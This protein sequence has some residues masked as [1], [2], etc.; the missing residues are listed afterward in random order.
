M[1]ILMTLLCTLLLS[2]S[3]ANDKNLEVE[4]MIAK[5]KL[6]RTDKS[7]PLKQDGQ[8]IIKAFKLLKKQRDP[9]LAKAYIEA[10]NKMIE[11]FEHY[12]YVE[13]FVILYDKNKKFFDDIINASLNKKDAKR[14][15]EL[16]ALARR[17]FIE[18]NG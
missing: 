13:D 10:T 6:V 12:A 4:K 16:M 18:G 1:K 5:L 17:V 15:Y 3:Y 7:A 14:F 8:T 11:Q 9:N 2:F